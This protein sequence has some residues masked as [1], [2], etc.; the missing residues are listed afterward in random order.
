MCAVWGGGGACSK[1]ISFAY[2]ERATSFEHLGCDRPL[3][4]LGLMR[5]GGMRTNGGSCAASDLGRNM[6]TYIFKTHAETSSLSRTGCQCQPSASI[7]PTA[8]RTQQCQTMTAFVKLCAAGEVG[9]AVNTPR[10]DPALEH[11]SPMEESNTV[12]SCSRPV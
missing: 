4:G 8:F 2:E 12:P 9:D 3:R 5:E 7:P 6:L 11:F 10:E 1:L